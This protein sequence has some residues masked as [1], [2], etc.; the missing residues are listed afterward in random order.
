MNTLDCLQLETSRY[1]CLQKCTMCQIS[2][3]CLA[4]EGDFNW[5]IMVWNTVNTEWSLGK[6]LQRSAF[7]LGSGCHGCACNFWYIFWNINKKSWRAEDCFTRLWKVS[8]LLPSMKMENLSL[9]VCCVAEFF[10]KFIATGWKVAL[11]HHLNSAF[12][13]KSTDHHSV[14]EHAAAQQTLT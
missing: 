12:L 4:C 5:I 9:C 2:S 7:A 13:K 6:F 3:S 14:T 1:F 11:I 10:A 8:D